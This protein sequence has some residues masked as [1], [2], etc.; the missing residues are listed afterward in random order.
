MTGE[1][2]KSVTAEGGRHHLLKDSDG[3]GY[4]GVYLKLHNAGIV[5][6]P[7][8]SVLG[9]RTVGRYAL[10]VCYFHEDI[11][12]CVLYGIYVVP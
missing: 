8:Q 10:L 9:H 11:V 5:Q 3:V 6:G 1:H 7:A 4:L 2:Y 12:V